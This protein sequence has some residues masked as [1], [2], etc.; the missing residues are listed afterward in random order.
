MNYIRKVKGETVSPMLGGGYS[1][2]GMSAGQK[3]AKK[4]VKI[5]LEKCYSHSMLY[6]NI[7]YMKKSAINWK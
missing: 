3:G 5:L 4:Y 1:N 2:W 7:R 6:K